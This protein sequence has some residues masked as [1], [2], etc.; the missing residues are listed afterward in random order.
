METQATFVWAEGRIELH[1]PAVV[2]L[3]YASIIYPR[4]AKLNCP[5]GHHHALKNFKLGHARV[6]ASH[7]L[8]RTYK[9]INR[10][11]K[12]RLASLSF[13]IVSQTLPFP[14]YHPP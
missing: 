13:F 6:G 8:N 4:N 12:F 14:L 10:L 9:L 11:F 1:T 7:L 2:H 5:L 3:Y